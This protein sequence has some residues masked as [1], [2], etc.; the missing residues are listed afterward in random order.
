[1]FT[2]ALGSSLFVIGPSYAETAGEHWNA[3]KSSLSDAEKEESIPDA[4]ANL[5]TAQEIYENHFKTAALSVDPESNVL[6]ENAFSDSK[7]KISEG[8]VEQASLN[9][10]IIDKTIYKIAFMQMEL[11]IQENNSE[12]FIYWYDVLNK[13][14]NLSENDQNVDKLFL[15]ITNDSSKLNA[16][17]PIILDKILDIFKLKTFEEIEEA[18]G[19]LQQ[20]D[21]KSAKKFAYEGLYY[22]RTFHPSVVEKLGQEDG[23]EFLHE[24]KEAVEITAS[25]KPLSEIL[26]ELENVSSEVELLIREYEGG[27]ISE[28]GLV[29][30][31]IKDRLNLVD[32]EYSDSVKDGVI[33]NQEEYD[34]TVIFLSKAKEIFNENKIALTELSSSDVSSLE[35]NISEI[36]KL[37]E[38]KENPNKVTILVSKSLNDISSLEEYAGGTLEI[39]VIQYIDQIEILLNEAKQEYANGDSQKAFDLVSEA[40]LDN[41]EFVEGPLG[42]VDPDLMEKIEIDMREDLRNMIQSDAPISE[43]DSQID[44]ILLD[45]E[46]ARVV[47][48]EFGT[49]AAIIL[50][51]AIISVIVLTSKT[52]LVLSPKF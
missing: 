31:G 52:R 9:R 15:E 42:E 28:V 50:A 44:M 41:Y 51:I 36:D 10:Q 34:E 48:P 20:D 14:F 45:L 26:E 13:K 35:K 23:D 3:I 39:D 30:S 5:Q 38:N 29:L 47:V 24:M 7:N 37:V 11:A 1:M 46:E 40:Y 21:I 16:N 27:N 32:I 4:L 18:V 12:N 22:Y 8:D 33:I 6:I 49:I 19:A 43:V 25:G 2:V 17:G